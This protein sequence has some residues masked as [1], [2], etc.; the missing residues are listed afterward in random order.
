M[1]HF[2]ANTL[3]HLRITVKT[4]NL[5]LALALCGLLIFSC[6]PPVKHY[7]KLNQCLIQQDYG[8]AI[9]ELKKNK[10]DYK[11]RNAA[12]YYLEE[13]L[14]YH[15]ASDYQ[16]STQSLAKAEGIMDELYT[17]S[18]SKEAASF[19]IND[20]TVPYSGE[21]F[22]NALVNLFMAL[23]YTAA[24]MREDALVEARKVDNKLN[25]IN[26]Q[27]DDDK[28]NVYDED[29][30]IRFLMGV[31]YE[32]G[33]EV[34]DAFISYRKAEE[35]YRT[36]YADNYGL[37]APPLLIENLLSSGKELSFNEEIAEIQ[38]AYPGVT[39]MDPA[40]KKEMAE[41][42]FI[43]YNGMGPEKVE[44]RWIVPMPD[45]YLAKIAYP[46]FQKK[47]YQIHHGDV[48][49]RDIATGQA[50]LFK[51]VLMEDI[52][53]IAV[54]NLENRL[55]RIKV[56]AIARATAKYLAT[57]TAS[58]VAEDQSGSLAGLLVQVAGNVAA[59]ATENADLRHWRMLP[60]EIRVGR[61]VVPP[62]EYEGDIRYVNASGLEICKRSLQKFT[63]Q[64]G[65]KKFLT[66]Q[67]MQ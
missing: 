49:V 62:G 17:K 50:Y 54:M 46:E 47:N 1:A 8:T 57:K 35:I 66:D 34:N 12:L 55:T 67:T 59:A 58:K 37:S 45:G 53:A 44:K 22:E 6:A 39:Y 40:G 18:I 32:A 7:V 15:Y 10:P 19:L 65:E 52:G 26:S 38:A 63:V 14:L 11:E 61:A 20:N 29:A 42:Y 4:L 5:V 51:T 27:Y 31:L 41:I 2:S 13:G 9:T 28:K 60:A 16:Q 36:D 3:K 30:F 21:D 33:G 56:K 64:A 23:N 24:G 48:F 25:V 43:H